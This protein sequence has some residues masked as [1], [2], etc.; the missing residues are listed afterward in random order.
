MNADPICRCQNSP[1]RIQTVQTALNGTT[2]QVRATFGFE[3]SPPYDILFSVV[4]QDGRWDVDDS[5]KAGVANSS[6]Y[7]G[8]G[9]CTTG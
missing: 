3:G 8:G 6:L 5:C 7:G 2:A 9:P 4:Q 1:F